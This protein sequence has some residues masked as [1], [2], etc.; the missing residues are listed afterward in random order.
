MKV[1]SARLTAEQAH[2]YA[3]LTQAR[4]VSLRG[5]QG[6]VLVEIPWRSLKAK[7][8]EIHRSILS[9]ASISQSPNRCCVSLYFFIYCCD[10]SGF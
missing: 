4:G 6:N 1:D 10:E 3:D 9:I 7:G 8:L 2:V 5:K